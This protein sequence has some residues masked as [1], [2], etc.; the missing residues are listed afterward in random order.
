MS[1]SSTRRTSKFH[2][3]PDPFCMDWLCVLTPYII[4]SFGLHFQPNLLTA[5]S[6][7]YSSTSYNANVNVNASSLPKPRAKW[8]LVQ[9]CNRAI[10]LHV[11]K[12]IL[13]CHSECITL[14]RNASHET[15]SDPTEESVGCSIQ[16]FQVRQDPIPQ[17][18]LEQDSNRIESNLEST[19]LLP[20]SASLLLK[21][22]ARV[23]HTGDRSLSAIHGCLSF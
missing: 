3:N 12:S 11:L 6:V 7:V 14:K 2:Q 22:R 20:M 18:S 10:V 9:Y 8:L 4:S 23:Q 19:R 5:V 1:S 13:S 16:V 17:V 15:K 21:S